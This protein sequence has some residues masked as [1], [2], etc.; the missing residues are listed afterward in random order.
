MKLID[1]TG[2]K[3]GKLAVLG[4]GERKKAG[5]YWLCKC[6][7][8]KEKLILG[9]HLRYG[10]TV[11]CGCSSVERISI[12]NKT[13]GETKTRLYKIWCGMICR[14]KNK[15]RKS[16]N[17][18]G[19]RGISVCD[20]WLNSYKSFKE[21]ALLNGYQENLTIDRIDVNGNY[22]PSNCRWSTQKEQSNNTRRTVFIEYEGK[23]YSA[24]QL[25][26]FLN[27]NYNKFLRSLRKTNF[28]I[29]KSI[30]KAK[31]YKKRRK[32]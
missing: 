8:G 29:A 32:L 25:S 5:V 4:I 27:I 21:W 30:E 19:A 28:D 2:K 24:K 15:N 13:H 17:I 11:S 31:L 18:Y 14:C 3:F 1:L 20:E 16:Y 23:K 22:E 6:D 26:E 10:G 7:C 12:L 9:Q